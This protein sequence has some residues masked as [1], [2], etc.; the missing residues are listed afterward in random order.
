M[1]QKDFCDMYDL[2][3]P[4]LQPG[5]ICPLSLKELNKLHLEADNRLPELVVIQFEGEVLVCNAHY[6]LRHLE[7]NRRECPLTGRRVS[8]TYRDFMK[9]HYGN[10]HSR[11]YVLPLK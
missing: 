11:P 3:F 9:R 6:Y 2:D 5:E 1:E 10:P 7:L 8:L 4:L